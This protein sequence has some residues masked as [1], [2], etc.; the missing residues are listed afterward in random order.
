MKLY[1]LAITILILT[2][3]AI[4]SAEDVTEETPS[5]LAPAVGI[6][7]SPLSVGYKLTIA[8]HYGIDFLAYIPVIETQK[9]ENDEKLSGLRF[10]GLVGYSFP[11]RL[12]E[13]IGFFMRPQFDFNYLMQSGESSG[14]ADLSRNVLTIRPGVFAGIEV[15]LEEI[16]IPDVNVQMGI[17]AGSEFMS[18]NLDS[19]GVE[20]KTTSF[21]G[22][23]IDKGYFGATLGIWWFF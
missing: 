5:R 15:F 19:G 2:A 12:E 22:P 20:F 13:N 9:T 18:E 11:L 4:F 8:D 7:S 21:G 10:G 3:S 14:G 23:L 16:G 17:T 6:S 1:M